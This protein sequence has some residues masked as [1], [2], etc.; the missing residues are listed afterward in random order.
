MST[1]IL[2]DTKKVL[3]IAEDYTIFDQDVLMHI[4]SAL[5]TLVQL[6]IGPTNGF[7]VEDAGAVWTDFIGTDLNLNNVR[8]YIYLRVRL[9]FDPPATSFLI[10][11]YRQQIL[12]LE[13]RINMHREATGW[14]DPF[15]TLPHEYPFEE[16]VIDGGSP[17]NP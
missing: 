17:D 2:T 1:S 9:L 5:V 4:N 8:S 14:I 16:I 12:E 15:S 3:G 11:A 13:S 6:G 7:M 10:D